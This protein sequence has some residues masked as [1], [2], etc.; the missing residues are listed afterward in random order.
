MA[1]DQKNWTERLRELW[2]RLGEA[3]DGLM[4]EPQPEL[5]P[6]PV[7]NRRPDPRDQQRR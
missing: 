6:I 5:V 1:G 2:E 7:R 4:G 3:V